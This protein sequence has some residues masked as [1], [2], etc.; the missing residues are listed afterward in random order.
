M[1]FIAL[2]TE[3]FH[4]ARKCFLSVGCGCYSVVSYKG[5]SRDFYRHL[6]VS[7]P[8]CQANATSQHSSWRHDHPHDSKREI[9]IK[10]TS[11]RR[12]IDIVFVGTTSIRHRHRPGEYVASVLGSRYHVAL[13]GNSSQLLVL[14]ENE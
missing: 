14:L 8:K 13:L 5:P 4:S 9:M 3:C 10:S 7:N 11:F 6:V 1:I 2:G 12:R